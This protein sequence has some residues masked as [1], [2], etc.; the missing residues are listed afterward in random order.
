MVARAARP[1]VGGRGRKGGAGG[2]GGNPGLWWGFPGVTPLCL[3]VSSFR[4]RGYCIRVVPR[5]SAAPCA[6]SAVTLHWFCFAPSTVMGT[7]ST[8]AFFL[9]R[10]RLT[11]SSTFRLRSGAGVILTSAARSGGEVRITEA[12]R[13][14]RIHPGRRGARP[15]SPRAAPRLRTSHYAAGI[16]TVRDQCLRAS[17]GGPGSGRT[18]RMK[19]LSS[20]NP[21]AAQPSIATWP[22]VCEQRSPLGTATVELERD[23]R[24]GQM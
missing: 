2:N 24:L 22:R 8:P 3:Q 23:H 19:I 18:R 20:I 11:S 12:E 9:L 5:G 16:W 13:S 21:A 10:F 6:P 7:D 17:S 15:E 1:W 4:R 14:R